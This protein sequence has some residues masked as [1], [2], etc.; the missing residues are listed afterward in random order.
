VNA[1]TITASRS[2][3]QPPAIFAGTLVRAIE[4][5]GFTVQ[6]LD[7][8]GVD[9]LGTAHDFE[10]LEAAPQGMNRPAASPRAAHELCEGMGV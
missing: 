2:D 5:H 6:R 4:S 7:V 10:P 1:L 3:G 9:V 8:N